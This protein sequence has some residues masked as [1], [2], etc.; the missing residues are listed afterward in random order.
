M[1]K[2]T[3]VDY[4]E[5]KN[6]DG[7]IFNSLILEGEIEMV[8]SSESGNYYATAKRTSI[9]STFTKERCEQLIG[10]TLPGTIERIS[11]EPYEYTLPETGEI[12]TL[13]HEYEFMPVGSMEN[14]VFE[15]ENGIETTFQD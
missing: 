7:E 2:V 14:E 4:K 6:K 1:S 5:R 3:I 10:T 9:T 11:C 8:Q 13:E 12:V 15:R